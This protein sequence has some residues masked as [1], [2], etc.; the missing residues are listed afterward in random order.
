MA[1]ANPLRD[2]KDNFELEL[3]QVREKIKTRFTEL[4]NR[5]K[6]RENELLR[7]LDTVLAFY[8]SFRKELERVNERKVALERTKSFHQNE[9]LT[10]PL[11]S[12]HE[13]VIKEVDRELNS[14]ETP[15]K[16]KMP[17]FEFDSKEML[18]ELNKLVEFVEKGSGIDYTS[19]KQPL[20]RVFKKGKGMEGLSWPCGVAVDKKTGNIYLADQFNNCIKV[21]DTTG[22]YLS[23]F[24]DSQGEGKIYLPR[25]V[26]IYGDRIFIT[27][28][29]SCILSYGLNAMFI[30]KRCK[31]GT[32]ESQFN[33]PS[34]LTIDESNGDIYICDRYNNR[35]Q[36]LFQDLSFKSQ[37]GKGTLKKPHDVKL[38][39]EYI[40][41]LD[42]SNPCLHL[43]NYNHIKQKSVISRGEGK[44]VFDPNFFELD[45]N[46]NILITD[47]NSNSIRIFNPQ[48]L[49]THTIATAKS[50]MCVTTDGEGRVIVSCQAEKGCLQIY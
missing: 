9:L 36:V 30:S 42:E 31:F 3:S 20:V 34:G 23:N 41:I 32:G 48:F 19:K 27:Q 26:A 37:F 18:A 1:G 15:M 12:I 29:T 8:L 33:Y 24:G 38:S 49:L 35:I 46:D 5:L 17:A 39:K 16:P 43:F 50:P 44:L 13:N 21:F 28:G 45:K 11:K 2:K 7:Q 22:K 47:C 10:S 4:T 6:A 40:Y 25:C 14:I